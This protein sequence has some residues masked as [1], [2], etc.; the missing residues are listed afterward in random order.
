MKVLGL[1]IGNPKQYPK[2]VTKV[3]RSNTGIFILLPL[4]NDFRHDIAFK[5]SGRLRSQCTFVAEI[6]LADFRER[7]ESQLMFLPKR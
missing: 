7:I 6:G 4:Q 1:Y 5:V 2:R 3:N